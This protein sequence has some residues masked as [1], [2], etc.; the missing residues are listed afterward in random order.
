VTATVQHGGGGASERW[1]ARAAEA[2]LRRLG[3]HYID[4]YQV[5]YPDPAVPVEETLGAL[6]ALVRAGKVREIGCCN[7][8]ADLIQASAGRGARPF[9]SLQLHLN[10]IRQ[11]AL[12]RDVPAAQRRPAWRCCPTGRS[13]R[14]C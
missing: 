11:R 5:H 10:L 14:G 3:T 7:Y 8:L 6:D 9:A 1:I 13:R 4:L 12:E 2:S